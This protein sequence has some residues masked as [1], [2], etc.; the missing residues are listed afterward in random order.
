MQ[1]RHIPGRGDRSLCVCNRKQARGTA[2]QKGVGRGKEDAFGGGE[3][4]ESVNPCSYNNGIERVK[5][6][7]MEQ[8]DYKIGKNFIL[9]A[10]MPQSTPVP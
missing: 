6:L 7:G 5:R 4:S 8:R 10:L 9:G 3:Q 2:A 1:E